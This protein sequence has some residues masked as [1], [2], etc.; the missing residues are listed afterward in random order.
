MFETKP[1]PGV[2]RST[3]RLVRLMC[4]ALC[5]CTDCTC[6]TATMMGAHSKCEGCSVCTAPRGVPDAAPALGAAPTRWMPSPFGK[7]RPLPGPLP[8]VGGGGGRIPSHRENRKLPLRSTA[9]AALHCS[10]TWTWSGRQARLCDQVGPVVWAAQPG[11]GGR[12]HPG[13]RTS[14]PKGPFGA[15]TGAHRP[16]PPTM[17]AILSCF[18]V[19]DDLKP[20]MLAPPLIV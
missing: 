19:V 8:G 15:P 11:A 14:G 6:C 1:G 12:G 10:G 18:E 4:D 17:M 2:I 3:V 20:G 13:P 5:L 7:G 9:A 16:P